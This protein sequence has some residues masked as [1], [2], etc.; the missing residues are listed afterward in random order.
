MKNLS[1]QLKMRSNIGI[2]T[3]SL[4]A[5][6]LFLLFSTGAI[7]QTSKVY[8]KLSDQAGTQIKGECVAKGFERWIEAL[9]INSAGKNNTELSFTMNITGSSAALKKAMGNN[10]LLLNGLV[11]VQT[12]NGATGMP[13]TAYT[14]TME[15]ITVVACTESMGCNNVMSTS[16]MLRSTRIGWT[17]YQASRSGGMSTVSNKYGWD[18]E[19][20]AAWIAF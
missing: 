11:S 14:I 5:C 19:A 20:N 9:T 3:T 8:I 7:A 10:E 1:N 4:F 6:M 16:V 17:Y 2:T 13:A 15:N 12:V 18:S